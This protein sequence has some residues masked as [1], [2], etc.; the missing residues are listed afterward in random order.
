MNTDILWGILVG[1][2]GMGALVYVG[3]VIIKVS[4]RKQ[5]EEEIQG[6]LNR[7]LR[8]LQQKETLLQQEI[9]YSS[10]LESDYN[11]IRQVCGQTMEQTLAYFEQHPAIW[12]EKNRDKIIGELHAALEYTG[13]ERVAPVALLTHMNG[14]ENEQSTIA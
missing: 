5:K 12:G 14:G 1:G 3:A 7:I 2:V 6:R 11:L 13:K 4:S 9:S 8:Q 10:R